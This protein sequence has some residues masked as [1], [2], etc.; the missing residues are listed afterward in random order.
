MDGATKNA[1]EDRE[2]HLDEFLCF[3]ESLEMPHLPQSSADQHDCLAERPPQHARV[4]RFGCLT[5]TV[6]TEI[7]NKSRKIAISPTGFRVVNHVFKSCK[8]RI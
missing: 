7:E 3:E 4:R 5:E 1:K 8:L 6:L 2:E